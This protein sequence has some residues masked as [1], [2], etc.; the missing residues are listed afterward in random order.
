MKKRG[1][2]MS[3]QSTNRS[4]SGGYN[5]APVT[6][7]NGPLAQY[8]IGETVRKV[9]CAMDCVYTDN[10][11]FYIYSVE[12]NDRWFLIKGAFPY[13]LN[14]NHY[15]EITGSVTIDKK[16]GTRQINVSVCSAV[17]PVDEKGILTVLKTLH[18]LNMQANKLYQIIG[19]DVLNI[20]I[21]DPAAIASK[22][23]IGIKRVMGWQQELLA[24]SA[25]DKELKKLYALGLTQQQ[26]TRLI[27]DHGLK[28]C[29]EVHV[30]PYRL[31]G[32]VRGYTFTK[33]DKYA[34]DN[35]RSARDLIRLSE[36]LLYTMRS[37]EM[38]GH[39]TYPKKEFMQ[40]A[41]SILDVSLTLRMAKQILREQKPGDVFQE[42]RGSNTYK[43]SIDDLAGDIQEW[44]SARHSRRE[45]YR[46][47]LDY[48]DDDLM[49][50]ALNIL[51]TNSKVITENVD[52]KE[53]V[54]PGVFY[55]AERAIVS[56]LR[57]IT[58]NERSPFHNV[59]AVMED[60]LQNLGVTLEKKQ[61]EAVRRICAC[62][63]GAYILNGSAGC[64]KTFTLNIIMKVL[65]VLYKSRSKVLNPC[66]LAPT[67][68]A[69]KVAAAATGLPA[70]TVHKA[71]GLVSSNNQDLQISSRSIGN[72]CIVVDEF[73]MVD[74]ILGAALLDGIPKTSKVIF[75]GDPQQLPSIRAGRLLKDLIHSEAVPVIT[76][77]VVKRQDAQSG[78]LYNAN[79]IVQ[80]SDIDTYA[81]NT[82]GTK[83]NAY[84][85][86]DSDQMSVQS[87]IIDMARQYGLKAFQEGN[88]QV[89]CPLKAGPVGV[90][91]L[92]YHLQQTLN[93]KMDRNELP[94]GRIKIRD[95]DGTEE[96]VPRVFRVGDCVI[97]I[98]NNYKQPWFIKHKING[99][100][101]TA[102]AGVVNGDTG[103]VEAIS[104]YKDGNNITHR[105]IYVKY[106]GHYIAYDNEYDDLALA[107]ALTIHKSQGSQWPNVI[108]PLVQPSIILNRKILYTMYT[109]AQESCTLIGSPALIHRTIQNNRE[110]LRL[111]LLE[112]R[113]RGKL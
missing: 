37:V 1:E 111:T 25:N 86:S 64:G 109:R 96:E 104:V 65:N 78:I 7:E 91:A 18:G 55:N 30:N 46:Y 11:G 62:E 44:E 95:A 20:I 90:E 63:G 40:A 81:P 57:D 93:P 3:C 6:E 110:D 5:Y 26:A 43:I 87:R 17:L 85:V 76:L 103:I 35:G 42:R 48:I 52:G 29:E 53:Y 21:K 54:T 83:G 112:E 15:Y 66:I 9:V 4:T 39:C 107:Y 19:P 51:R 79:R 13:P 77:D 100:I 36:G 99:F 106:D 113:L 27:A 108:C 88:V 31:I 38:R 105:V 75:L 72:N 34:L 94:V 41:H 82:E 73:S 67:G 89:L 28:I 59:D 47:I 50:Q 45:S 10:C 16:R 69:A 49:E 71:L 24:K 102:S 61:M 84:V 22:A 98:R 70:Q 60:I 33:C 32:E 80:G 58:G 68:K 101:E 14:L 2:K 23:G 92:N 74:E 56:S 97:N 12:E 8:K